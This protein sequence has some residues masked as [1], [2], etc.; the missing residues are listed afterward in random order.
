MRRNPLLTPILVAAC[1]TFLPFTSHAAGRE[2]CE[3]P[4][5][6]IVLDRS[7]SMKDNNKWSTA[8]NALKTVVNTHGQKLRFGL[9]MFPLGRTKCTPGGVDIAVGENTAGAIT[10]LLN[11]TRPEGDG[12]PIAGSLQTL[13]NYPG[14]QD[15]NRRN[16]ILL[17]TD[18]G[19]NCDRAGRTA[20]INVVKQLAGKNIKTYVVGFGAGV[21]PTT[22]SQMAVEGGTARQ[23]NPKYY[24]ADDANTLLKALDFI[25]T[26]S[27]REIC[28]GLDNDCN[29]KIDDIAPRACE[30]LCGKKGEQACIAGVWSQC[31]IPP[32]GE[33]GKPCEIPGA[34]GV[35]KDGVYECDPAGN[36]VCK[37]KGQSSPEDCNGLDDDCDGLVDEGDGPGGLTRPCGGQCG[38]GFEKCIS[39]KWD[40]SSCTGQAPTNACLTCGPTPGEICDGKDNDCD[41][42][43]DEGPVCPI[44]SECIGGDCVRACRSGECPTGRVCREIDGQKLCIAPEDEACLTTKCPIGQSCVDGQCKDMCEGV[45]CKDGRVCSHGSCV[46]LSCYTQ[47]CPAGESCANGAC[48]PDPCAAVSCQP[49][50]FCKGGQCVKSCAGT[51]C[52]TG[53]KCQDGACAEDPCASQSCPS[54]DVCIAGKCRPNKCLEV[55][56]GA[57][58]V[59]ADGKCVDDPCLNIKCPAGSWCVN[60]QCIANSQVERPNP[61]PPDAGAQPA[62]DAGSD[63]GSEPD[64]GPEPEEDASI[65]GGDSPDGKA[66]GGETPG[67]GQ[68]PGD[69]LT[70]PIAPGGCGCGMTPAGSSALPVSLLAL[71]AVIILRRRRMDTRR[72]FGY[73]KA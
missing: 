25:I 2:D 27:T 59:C 52:K 11:Q 62:P 49:D 7:G 19:E 58:R 73:K 4:N 21:D 48:A 23:G 22:L 9:S 66:S 37:P 60:G 35:C 46:E 42:Q 72:M 14:L 31:S 20:P 10:S 64:A 24:Q 15:P 29:L 12:T 69:G 70:A 61:N 56:C 1:A 40:A 44:G 34:K 3:I 17:V 43:Y 32:K 18:G 33:E 55:F 38:S 5:M 30:G 6:M 65:P 63:D 45:V 57:G 39:G 50:E 67:P 16:F 28:D 13:I 51:Q 71:A 68:T 36:V 54:P 41:G 8:V 47:G 53:E 26:E